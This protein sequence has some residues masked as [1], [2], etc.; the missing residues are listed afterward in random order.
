MY[1]VRNAHV[2]SVGCRA[3]P[4]NCCGTSTPTDERNIHKQ[5]V[6]CNQHKSGNLVPYRVE[7]INRI[8]QEAVGRNRI[9]TIAAIAGLSKSARRSRQ[10]TNR[11][12]KTCEIAEVRP[13]D[14]LSKTIPD[15]FEAYG[16]QTEVVR[17]LKCSRGTVR[18]YVDDK[19]GK[20]HAIVNDVLMVHRGWSERDALL[21]KN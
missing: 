5:C 8:G 13:H 1:L 14:V 18:K 7:L 15:I 2:C 19:D 9:K 3:L 12:S 16:N 20:M 4:D 10:S 21:R 17:R 6:V 11:N